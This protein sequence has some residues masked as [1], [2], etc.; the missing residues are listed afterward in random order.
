MRSLQAL[1]EYLTEAQ[2]QGNDRFYATKCSATCTKCIRASTWYIPP[3]GSK[4]ISQ[5]TEKDWLTAKNPSE[6]FHICPS[7]RAA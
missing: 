2:V 1:C 7:K 5:L 6:A 3:L 4:A